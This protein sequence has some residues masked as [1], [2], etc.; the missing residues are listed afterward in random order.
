MWGPSRNDGFRF[1]S[2]IFCPLYYEG[3][4]PALI[5]DIKFHGR[6]ES[7]SIPGA[8]L[9]QMLRRSNLAPGSKGQG[10]R[11]GSCGIPSRA[12]APAVLVPIP[13]HRDRYRRRG[14]NQAE[15]IAALVSA[16][17]G[18]P[19][20]PDMLVRG[21]NTPAQHLQNRRDRIQMTAVFAAS[22]RARGKV[23]VLVDD[24]VTTGATMEAA[25]QALLLQ[26]ARAVYYAAAAGNLPLSP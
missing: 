9:A 20:A 8:L 16:A 7:A 11:D 18:I 26:G 15:T 17:T 24:V 2:G 1:C 6:R 12:A 22:P 14:Y 3:R 10:G 13:L 23:V 21:A 4:V 19:L 5:A 25:A